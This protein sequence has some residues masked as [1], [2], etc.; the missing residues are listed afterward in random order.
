MKKASIYLFIILLL[1]SCGV[2]DNEQNLSCT[3][4]PYIVAETMPSLI[5]G[6]SGLQ[7]NLVYPQEA[8]D[9]GI[10][11]RVTVQFIVNKKGNVLEPRIIRGIGGG[12]DEAAIEAVTMS[13]FSPGMQ[14]GK[15]VC[16]QYSLP[17]V[18]RL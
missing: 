15:P 8:I 11:G 1:Q 12:A 7:S 16:V 14:N 18:F 10:E 5:G 17:I 4:N 13:K 6:L 2:F 3:D 9:Q